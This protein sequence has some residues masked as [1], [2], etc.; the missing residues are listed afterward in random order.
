MK[1]SDCAYFSQVNDV[2]GECRLNPPTFVEGQGFDRNSPIS[3]MYVRVYLGYFCSKFHSK[4]IVKPGG[5]RK[6]ASRG[7]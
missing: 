4:E 7:K 5:R 6:P 3:Y 2:G 1:C